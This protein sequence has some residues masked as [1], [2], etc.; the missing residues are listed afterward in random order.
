MKNYNGADYERIHYERPVQQP[1]TV[2]VFQSIERPS[3]TRVFGT[4]TP[5]RGLSGL[6]RQFA[7]K[8]SEADARHWLSLIVADRVNVVEGILDDLA[9]GYVPNFFAERG[10]GAEWK[11]NRN[12]AIKRLAIGAAIASVALGV[13]VYNRRSRR[14]SHASR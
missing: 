3:M 9:R 5:P 4:S 10:W 13:L 6:V 14:I 1:V 7:F 11:Y 8:F 2:D 12:G